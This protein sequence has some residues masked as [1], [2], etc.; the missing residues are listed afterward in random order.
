M[1]PTDQELTYK[2]IDDI[3]AFLKQWNEALNVEADALGHN[4]LDELVEKLRATLDVLV[5]IGRQF[6]QTIEHFIEERQHV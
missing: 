5:G 4:V 3:D 1:D 2:W 6:A